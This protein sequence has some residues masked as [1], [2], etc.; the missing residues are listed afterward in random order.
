MLPKIYEDNIKK[1]NKVVEANKKRNA[2]YKTRMNA[3]NVN[4]ND[5]V[6]EIKNTGLFSNQKAGSKMHHHG[7]VIHRGPR[8]GKYVI[9]NSKKIYL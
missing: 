5:K 8:G 3:R 1:A 2:E 9:F 7:H 4:I 6:E